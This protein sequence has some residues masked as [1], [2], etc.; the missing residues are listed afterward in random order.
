MIA[1]FIFLLFVQQIIEPIYYHEAV[2]PEKIE[3]RI[4]STAHR[5][6]VK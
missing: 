4:V 5:F 3:I 2:E 6:N 1:S